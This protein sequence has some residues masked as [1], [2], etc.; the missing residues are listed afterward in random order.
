MIAKFLNHKTLQ[1]L[2]MLS[3]V[4]FNASII[5][6]L[7]ISLISAAGSAVIFD[8]NSELYGPLAG[9]LR[10]MLIYLTLSQFAAYCFCSYTQ[11]YRPLVP[12]GLFWL[13]LMG[14]IEFYGMVNQIPI[15]ED[16]GRV[17][18][19]LGLSNLVYGG[20]MVLNGYQCRDID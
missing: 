14:S 20:L 6:L 17:F 13:L 7:I 16:Y 8:N 19:Y 18:L 12:V 4:N 11:N 10:L 9:N 3:A 5:F 1:L 2:S 15:D